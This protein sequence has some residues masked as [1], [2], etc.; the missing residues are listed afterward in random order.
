[1]C[2]IPTTHPVHPYYGMVW[3]LLFLIDVAIWPLQS[4]CNIVDNNI[5]EEN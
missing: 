5:F 4:Q 1:M 2:Q 3:Y